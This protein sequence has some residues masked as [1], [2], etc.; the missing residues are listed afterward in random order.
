MTLMS[1]FPGAGG[2]QLVG[3][4]SCALKSAESLVLSQLR[5]HTWVS[6]STPGPDN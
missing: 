2:A 6:S 4:M 5:A 3:A 1:K